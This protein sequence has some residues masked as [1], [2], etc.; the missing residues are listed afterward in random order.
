[1]TVS[2][3]RSEVGKSVLTPDTS[4]DNERSEG[5]A[6]VVEQPQKMR[7]V[8][9]AT[10][11]SQ[12]QP[13]PR[14]SQTCAPSQVENEHEGPMPGAHS[15]WRSLFSKGAQVQAIY[16]GNETIRDRVKS[17]LADEGVQIAATAPVSKVTRDEVTGDATAYD[18]TWEGGAEIQCTV[19][20]GDSEP[21]MRVDNERTVAKKKQ[22]NSQQKAGGDADSIMI[23][24]M[25][26]TCAPAADGGMG[27]ASMELTHNETCVSA[28]SSSGHDS[29]G[30][31]L[32]RMLEAKTRKSCSDC[33]QSEATMRGA[34]AGSRRFLVCTRRG[35]TSGTT[36]KKKAKMP[37]KLCTPCLTSNQCVAIFAPLRS[38]SI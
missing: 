12:Q 38:V 9:W 17:I 31:E 15:G 34:G 1:M 13:R 37:G 33:R 20:D 24:L 30:E 28:S 21:G 25:G 23:E 29:A 36:G 7:K 26:G 18:I 6:S 4:S 2:P 19:G 11:S 35:C 16:L 14:H 5:E 8:E 22:P 3:T 32:Q 27:A 10:A